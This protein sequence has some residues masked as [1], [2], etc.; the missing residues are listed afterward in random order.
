MDLL[1]EKNGVE[2]K[3]SS[4]GILVTDVEDSSSTIESSKRTVKNRSG[5]VWAGA[6]YKDRKVSIS[7]WLTVSNEFAFEELKDQ[8]N[9]LLIDTEPF[10]I[11]KMYPSN[12]SMYEFERPG[13]GEILDLLSIPHQKYKYSYLVHIKDG[14]DIN[15]NFRGRSSAG[16]TFSFNVQFVTADLPFGMTKPVDESITNQQILYSG[17][18]KCSQLEWPFVIKLTASQSQ[19]ASITLKIGTN[20]FTYKRSTAIQAGDVFLLK[21]IESTLNSNNVNEFT[22][23]EH[24]TLENGVNTVE[25]NFIGTIQILNKVEFYK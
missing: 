14:E 1:I 22:N 21:G 12:D 17:S 23:Y 13:S 20:T 8:I 15:Y 5:S 16:L 10:L 9:A 3:L 24:F 19:T 11:T 7:G 4:L 6:R 25:T 2:T 18:A